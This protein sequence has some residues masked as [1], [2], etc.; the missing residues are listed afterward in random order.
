MAEMDP[1]NFDGAER[2]AGESPL[3]IE[4]PALIPAA[5]Y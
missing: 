3:R 2:L 1:V 5:R 4:N